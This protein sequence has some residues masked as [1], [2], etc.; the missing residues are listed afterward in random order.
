[1]TKVL[2]E[3]LSKSDISWMIANGH[4]QEVAS[5][6]ILIRQ[7]RTIKTFYIVLEGTLSI[8]IKAN[9]ESALASAFAALENSVDLEQEIAQFSSGE[10]LGEMSFFNVVPSSTTV[11]AIENSVVLAFPYQKLLARLQRDV[12]FASRFYHAIAILL[13]NRFERLMK[14]FS[15]NRNLKIPPL[16]D[17]P[18]LF[19]EL[20]DSD[21]DWM[22][23]NSQVEEFTTGTTLIQ[24]GQPVEKI[25]ILLRGTVS[26]SFTEDSTSS[27]SRLF[28]ILESNE[29]NVNSSPGYEIS[30][31]SKGEILGDTA[32]I[33][34][35]L[36]NY[37]YKALENLQLLA[38]KK[39]HLLIKVQQ[40]PAM[41]SRFYRVIAMLLSARLEG[42]ISRLGYGR[43]SYQIGQ[44]LSENFSYSDEIDL[45]AIDNITIGGARFNWM[46]RRLKVLF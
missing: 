18:L 10:V 2:I 39:Q 9:R 32:L 3:Q 38:I 8:T 22:I 28:S 21:I 16:Q 17:V 41:A 40:N 34:A 33:D 5:G 29:N 11:K 23:Q 12:E 7:Q 27:I 36:S 24:S 4:R 15:R 20:N 37:T 19:G 14:K 31:I 45:D 6:T 30:Q 46:L 26:V 1:M 43:D 13:L 44:K 25:Y 35:R 42:L